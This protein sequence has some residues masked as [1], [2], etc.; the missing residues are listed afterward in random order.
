MADKQTLLAL[1]RALPPWCLEEQVR[2]YEARVVAEEAPRPSTAT[3]VAQT[4]RSALRRRRYG[5]VENVEALA[6][7]LGITLEVP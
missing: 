2:G 5:L 1:C 7:N 3:V 4:Y 6:E